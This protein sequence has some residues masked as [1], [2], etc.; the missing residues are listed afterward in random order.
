MNLQ[1]FA[2]YNTNILKIVNDGGGGSSKK[3]TTAGTK[4]SSTS[5]YDPNS[6]VDYLKQQGQ[7]SSYSARKQLAQQL[8]IKN[9]EGSGTQNTKML[10][11]LKNGTTGSV[12]AG[13]VAGAVGAGGNAKKPTNTPAPAVE[14]VAPAVTTPAVT[15]PPVISG[16]DSSLTDT[17]NSTFT[18]PSDVTNAQTNATSAL[19]TVTSMPTPSVSAETMQALNTPFSASSAYIEAMNY[20][21]SLLEKLSSGRT[22]YTDQIKD[23][24]NQI[25]NRDKFSYDVDTDMLF[26]QALASAMGSG[27]QAMQDTIGQASA[28]TGGYANTYATSAGNQAYNAYIEDAYNNL[29]EYYQMALEAY[30]MEGQEMYN[31]L[32]MLSDADASEYQRMY[33][34]WN[35][36]FA[37]AQQMYAQEYGAWQDSVNN[38]YKSADLQLKEQ[39]MAYDQ[40]YSNYTA[41]ADNANTLYTNAYNKWADEVANAYNVANLQNNDYW[42]TQ[43]NQYRYDAM[44]NDNYWNGVDNTYRYDVMEN[45]N[46]QADLDRQQEDEWNQK[47]YDYKYSAL[48]QD[49]SQ[50]NSRYD[51]NGDGVVDAKDTVLANSTASGD[52]NG[53]MATLTTRERDT[54][55]NLVLS[56][57]NDEAGYEA[58]RDYLASIGK[59]ET[60]FAELDFALEEAKAKRDKDEAEA[61]AK[62]PVWEKEWNIVDDTYNG[63]FLGTPLWSGTDHNDTFTDGNVT[64]TYDQLKNLLEGSNLSK[65]QKKEFLA[66]LT[67]QSTK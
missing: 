61:Y 62:L 18:A 59:S 14:P 52:D 67:A 63:G 8:G 56:A 50:F 53:G 17:M 30:N 66:K 15:A 65:E 37:N 29:P 10:N 5:G 28:L 43:D 38:A 40:A 49:Q 22:S 31:Q 34:S 27:R 19:N 26:Q 51:L 1:L 45:N 12:G 3:D 47:E 9:Y 64:Y 2:S 13:A 4:K 24:M 23:M 6:I 16:V 21:N 11:M 35:S 44:A 58:G 48:A 36:N 39:G 33:D 41:F 55:V 60:D 25:Q 42:N 20:T 46:E 32:S 54:F 57:E 7:D